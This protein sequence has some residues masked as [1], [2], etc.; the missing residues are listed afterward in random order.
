[1]KLQKILLFSL[2]GLNKAQAVKLNEGLYK[3]QEVNNV[4]LSCFTCDMGLVN[5]S[6]SMM[7]IEKN[8]VFPH[9]ILLKLILCNAFCGLLPAT[10]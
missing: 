2:K 9:P 4:V 3:T 1:M 7:G 8:L 6:F 10:L 5:I